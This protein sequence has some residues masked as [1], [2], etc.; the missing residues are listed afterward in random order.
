[1][2]KRL[3]L[4]AALSEAAG[5]PQATSQNL[6]IKDTS[7]AKETKTKLPPSRQGKKSIGGHFDPAVSR[8][9]K[10]IAVNHD[11]TVQALLVEAL[12]DL[13]VKYGKSPIA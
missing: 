9:L 5:K 2:A 7:Q 12:N 8:Q 1:M 11:T 3:K 13:F 4:A 10:Q 6:E